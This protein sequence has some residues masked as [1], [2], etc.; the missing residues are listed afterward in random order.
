MAKTKKKKKTHHR[1]KVG[2]I[3]PQTMKSLEM[4]GGALIGGFAGWMGYTK[5]NS[6]PN[7]VMGFGQFAVG[8]GATVLVDE[9]FVKGFGMGLLAVSAI[10]GG[11]AV[12]LLSGVGEVTNLPQSNN[13]RIAGYGNV[14]QLGQ[15][16]T[17]SFPKPMAV[18]A[19]LPKKY[20]GIYNR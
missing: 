2:A 5:I 13:L 12:G 17:S 4:L 18:G 11:E 1:R 20:A 6:V 19:V 16:P 10:I 8:A 7:A 9:P 15:A 14:K 3:S